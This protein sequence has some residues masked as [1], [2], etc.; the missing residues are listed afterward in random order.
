MR[1][2]QS[3]KQLRC[4]FALLAG[5]VGMALSGCSVMNHSSGGSRNLGAYVGST[6]YY[7]DYTT[8]GGYYTPSYKQ[9]GPRCWGYLPAYFP[10][11]YPGLYGGYEHFQKGA[12]GCDINAPACDS[13]ACE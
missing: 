7:P 8:T 2:P 3:H 11:C 12:S 1:K 6:S 5:S 10:G 9:G 13:A 4:L